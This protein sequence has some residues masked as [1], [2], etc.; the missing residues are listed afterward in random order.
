MNAQLVENS[1]ERDKI[2]QDE[3]VFLS[4]SA[5]KFIFSVSEG[6]KSFFF[7]FLEIYRVI[8]T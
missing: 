1:K 3:S 6:M 7:S 2:D 8:L 4:A 5:I